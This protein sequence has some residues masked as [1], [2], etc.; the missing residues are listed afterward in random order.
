[1]A[2]LQG[3][4]P[5][6]LRQLQGL[7][8]TSQCLDKE[9]I[10][11]KLSSCGMVFALTMGVVMYGWAANPCRP[12]A[13]ACMLAGYYKGGESKGKGLIKNCVMPVVAHNKTLPNTNFSKD[14]LQQC[15]DLIKSQL[16]DKLKNK[17]SS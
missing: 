14:D 7:I 6:N 15:G 8:D 10:M 9:F 1:M 13:R 16:K 11:N 2:R 12:I 3:F 4:S 17:V 5:V